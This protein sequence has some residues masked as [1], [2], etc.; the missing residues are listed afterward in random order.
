[1]TWFLAILSIIAMELTVRKIWWAWG[2]TLL[3]QVFW[4]F[5]LLDTE[6]YG[7]LLLT[8]AMT[9]QA[10]RGMRKWWKDSHSNLVSM[11]KKGNA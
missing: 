1:M 10:L 3:N 2:L 8:A 5:Y 4:A 6:Q 9:I 7:L 11:N